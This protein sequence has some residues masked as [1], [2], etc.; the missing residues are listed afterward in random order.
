MLLEGVTTH[1]TL[2]VQHA[3]LPIGPHSRVSSDLIESGTVQNMSIDCE[4]GAH[5]TTTLREVIA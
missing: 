2:K 5:W 3:P 4:S 1:S